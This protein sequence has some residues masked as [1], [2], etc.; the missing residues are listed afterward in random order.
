MVL[1]SRKKDGKNINKFAL[2]FWQQ[3]RNEISDDNKTH[4]LIDDEAS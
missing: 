3:Q 2:L 4:E 1:F